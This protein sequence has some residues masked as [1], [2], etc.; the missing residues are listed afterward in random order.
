VKYQEKKTMKP[1]EDEKKQLLGHFAYEVRG[2]H[3]S[4]SEMIKHHISVPNSNEIVVI[5]D[6]LI[7]FIVRIRT[8]Y[9]F[10]Y[11][12]GNGDKA[13]AVH[14]L[15]NWKIKKPLE[16]MKE[17]KIQIN[18]YLLHLSY[19]RVTGKAGWGYKKYTPNILYNHFRDLVIDFLNKLSEEY[20]NEGLQRLLKELK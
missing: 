4:Y 10:F 8:L 1:T 16:N 9:E 13:Y 11:E 7:S 19:N 6:F 18:N 5:E 15:P 14:Y 20:M 12:S 2:M 17:W 3:G